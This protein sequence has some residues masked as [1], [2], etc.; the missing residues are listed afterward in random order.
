MTE[1]NV[2]IKLNK[3]YRPARVS[4]ARHRILYGGAG[5]GKSHY[6][7]Q[8]TILN[9]LSNSH[10]H[11]L[12]VRKTGKSIRYS[13][14]KLLCSLIA[15]YNLSSKFS[16]NKSEM[17]ITCST[18]SSLITS[19]LDDV[20]KLKSVAGINRIWIEEA[21]EI[22]KKD[23]DQL[24]LRLRGQT[25]VSFQMTSTFNPIS[26]THWLKKVFF[27]V[28]KPNSFILKTTYLDNDFIDEEYKK[29]LDGLKEEDLQYYRIYA[30]GE[31]G[32]IGNLVYSNWEKKDFS[33]MIPTFDKI[34]NGLDWGFS[35]DPYAYVKL[36]HDPKRKEIYIYDEFYIKDVFVDD[37][38]EMLRT[39]MT[40]REVVVCDSSEPRSIR[41]LKRLGIKAEAAVKGPGSVEHGIKWIKS[42]KIYVMPT[43]INT[44][45]ELSTYKWKEGRDGSI[46]NIP[47]DANNHI[48]DALRYA[49]ESS[50][51]SSMSRLKTIKK[52][53]LG[54]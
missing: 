38:A 34:Y 49:L 42:H 6:V 37:I 39:K 53:S 46:L 35:Q 14:F 23:Y 40:A 16:I 7:A 43:C 15:E 17:S 27:D 5:S 3:V 32:S 51:S 41:D 2:S 8:E 36:H 1:H 52:S 25:K 44:I 24:D 30:L 9:M 12:I 13:V 4:G 22:S 10:Y 48:L 33:D 31:W 20:E 11:Y 47:V 26:D 45:K 28:G 50:V 29:T 19:G 54:L 18:G 21:S